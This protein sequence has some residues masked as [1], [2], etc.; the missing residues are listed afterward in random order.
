MHID[1]KTGRKQNRAITI[2]MRPS[3]RRPSQSAALE[4]M[5]DGSSGSS[6]E[7]LRELHAPRSSFPPPCLAGEMK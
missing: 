1:F 5:R 7:T 6:G 2:K 3:L 4:V